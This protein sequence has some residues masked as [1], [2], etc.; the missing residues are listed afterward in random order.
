MVALVATAQTDA[1]KEKL[2][3]R[4][5][6]AMRRYEQIHLRAAFEQQ[7]KLLEQGIKI[8]DPH[9]PPP[10]EA[11]ANAALQYA[12]TNGI[13]L[14]AVLEVAKAQVRASCTTLKASFPNPPPGDGREGR[15]WEL[16]GQGSPES[17]T[18]YTWMLAVLV[19]TGDLSSL[20]FIEEMR[21][22]PNGKIRKDAINAYLRLAGTNAVSFRALMADNMDAESELMPPLLQFLRELKIAP[23]MN[24]ENALFLY[25]IAEKS[26]DACNAKWVDDILC[27]KLQGYSNS[28]QRLAVAKRHSEKGITIDTLSHYDSIVDFISIKEA[29]EKIP[30]NQRKDFRAKGELLDPER[31][32]EP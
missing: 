30:E 1:E 10:I 12:K 11:R 28:V 23:E 7:R 4:L 3:D 9:Y 5:L 29:I 2:A 13:P 31:K 16:T 20:P 19:A 32:K 26:S 14:E 17:T 15:K 25:D 6:E 24:N 21:H 27:E 22:S 8:S 18:R